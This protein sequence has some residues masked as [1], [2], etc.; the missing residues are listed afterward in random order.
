[1]RKNVS[2]NGIFHLKVLSLT[3]F[4]PFQLVDK[5]GKLLELDLDT[6]FTMINLVSDQE[7]Q[8]V[9]QKEVA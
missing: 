8:I 1:M 9:L 4:N 7:T 3:F 5:I 2:L 6:V